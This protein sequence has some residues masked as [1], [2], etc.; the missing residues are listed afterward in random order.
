MAQFIYG[1]IG[2]IVAL[3]LFSAGVLL[4]WKLN[5]SYRAHAKQ[6]VAKELTEAERR[7]AKEDAEAFNTM[8]NYSSDVAYGIARLGE[9]DDGE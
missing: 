9:K 3:L 6:T 8:M 1:A 2:V 5:D 4:G 7:R